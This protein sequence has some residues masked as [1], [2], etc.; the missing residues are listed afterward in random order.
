MSDT[1]RSTSTKPKTPWIQELF[2]VLYLDLLRYVATF[3]AELPELQC[4]C[5]LGRVRMPDLRICRLNLSVA[6]FTVA[7]SP[8]GHML[9]VGGNADGSTNAP[10]YTQILS[11]G[12]GRVVRTL[13]HKDTMHPRVAFSPVNRLVAV[14]PFAD[15][16][17]VW[18]AKT[19]RR[20]RVLGYKQRW[21]SVAFSSDGKKL[22]TSNNNRRDVAVW[23]VETGEELWLRRVKV[24]PLL[25]GFSVAVSP[26]GR[27]IGSTVGGTVELLELASGV[28]RAELLGHTRSIS[29]VA[30][31]PDGKMLASG[32][33]DETVILWDVATGARLNTLRTGS[34]A[35]YCVAFSTDGRTLAVNTS[36]RLFLWDVASGRLRATVEGGTDGLGNSLSFSP[37]GTHLAVGSRN[38]GRACIYSMR[39]LYSLT[40][41]A[42]EEKEVEVK[43]VEVKA[44]G[45]KAEVVEV[46]Y[47]GVPAEEHDPPTSYRFERMPFR[48]PFRNP[49]VQ[50]NG[51]P[52]RLSAA[53][54]GPISLHDPTWP[55][56]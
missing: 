30:F 21:N 33:F 56:Y 55:W 24:K 27:T 17:G 2:S 25:D 41:T 45:E 34:A 49:P 16:I 9:V 50:F 51:P 14:L 1:I 38:K 8:D 54:S 36:S 43:E 12:T 40:T 20:V 5:L 52:R 35:V 31:S 28:R 44:K 22:V 26:D 10:Y 19:G 15:D 6:A 39:Y 48:M 46:Y 3:L 42:E 32:S 7:Y 18:D 23:R 4:L 11:A 47:P 13:G 53:S 37:D 29:S